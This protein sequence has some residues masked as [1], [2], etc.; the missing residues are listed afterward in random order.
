MFVNGMGAVAMASAYL[1]TVCK[2]KC[3]D[4]KATMC[5]TRC[6]MSALFGLEDGMGGRE[7][8]SCGSGSLP[9]IPPALACLAAALCTEASSPVCTSSQL[10]SSICAYYLNLSVTSPGYLKRIVVGQ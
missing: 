7:P 4:M 8:W 5:A 10:F 3:I 1:Y 6:G 2:T 9:P